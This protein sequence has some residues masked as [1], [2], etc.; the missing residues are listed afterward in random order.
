MIKKKKYKIKEIRLIF[1]NLSKSKTLNIINEIKLNNNN[2]ISELEKID[3]LINTI[4]KSYPDN[5]NFI[6][7]YSN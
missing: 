5:N 2:L 6:E 4:E 7:I 1:D 3:N